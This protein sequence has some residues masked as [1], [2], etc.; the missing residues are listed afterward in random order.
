VAWKGSDCGA[1]TRRAAANAWNRRRVL[2]RERTPNRVMIALLEK[3][4]RD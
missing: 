4:L 2:E 1:T 3:T